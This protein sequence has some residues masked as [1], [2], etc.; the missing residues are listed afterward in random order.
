[1]WHLHFA[2]PVSTA[3]FA[4]SLHVSPSSMVRGCLANLLLICVGWLAGMQEHIKE[5]IAS[6]GENIQVRRFSR[7]V[8][9]EGIEVSLLPVRPATQ[10]AI[11]AAILH[12]GVSL[13][14]R[15]FS[16]SCLSSVASIQRKLLFIDTQKKEVD[17]AAEVAAQTGGKL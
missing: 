2:V 8:L 15:C 7:F 3:Y 12:A 17:F 4:M 5:Q 10:H 6:I 11:Q 9:G 14:L 1:M 16:V 13:R